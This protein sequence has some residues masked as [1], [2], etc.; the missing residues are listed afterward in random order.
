LNIEER[1]T[2]TAEAGDL[3]GFGPEDQRDFGG[4]VFQEKVTPM[5]FSEGIWV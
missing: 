4:H 2:W 3:E 5:P 1:E